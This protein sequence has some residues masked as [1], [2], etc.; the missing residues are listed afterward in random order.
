MDTKKRLSE[1][2]LEELSKYCKS[3][4]EQDYP[5][6]EACKARGICER[7]PYKWK[8]D[9]FT[10]GEKAIMRACGAK[11]VTKTHLDNSYIS[12]WKERPICRD[13]DGHYTGDGFIGKLEPNIFPSLSGGDCIELED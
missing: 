8:F 2:T 3:M 9:T 13:R 7:T 12:L 10:D 1:W 5:K 11:W 4:V 6:C